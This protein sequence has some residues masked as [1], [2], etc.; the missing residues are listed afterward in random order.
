MAPRKKSIQKPTDDVRDGIR[1]R[2]R[3]EL[4]TLLHI[5]TAQVESVN[6]CYEQTLSLLRAAIL[7]CMAEG[8]RSE[9]DMSA[10]AEVLLSALNYTR[11]GYARYLL[12]E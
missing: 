3:A 10:I 2:N 8:E 5:Y 4:E 7:T 6:A 12:E 1:D 9:D 11:I